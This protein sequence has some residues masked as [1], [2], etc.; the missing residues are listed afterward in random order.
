MITVGEV[1]DSCGL[2]IVGNKSI[3]VASLAYAK[4][5]TSSDIAVAFS[6]KDISIT[7]AKV[8]L[9]EPCI[10]ITDKTLIYCIY[11]SILPT[12][13]KIAIFFKEK[14]CLPD[15]H[16]PPVYTQNEHGVYVGRNLQIGVDNYIAPMVTIGDDVKIGSNCYIEPNVFIGSGTEIGD[17]CII[18]SGACIGADSFLHYEEQG[19]AK[20]FRG[21]GRVI[22][23]DGVQVGYNSVIQ[24]GTISDTILNNRVLIGNLVIVAHDVHIGRDSRIV[25]QSGIAGSAELGSHVK[26]LGQSGVVNDVNMGDYSTLLAKSVATKNVDCGK[27][28][29]GIYGR[30]HKEELK[31]QARC[32]RL[33]KEID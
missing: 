24:R 17:H 28:I 4:E 16:V 3:G 13:K 10:S 33:L 21:I 7:K 2:S 31:L 32:R 20:S 11:G 30:E 1:A 25:C 18:H 8:V 15:Y 29:S 9:T 23:K 22:I 12:L 27:T 14:R 26:L 5:A 6:E 19:E